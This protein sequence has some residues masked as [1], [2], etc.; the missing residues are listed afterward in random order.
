MTNWSIWINVSFIHMINYQYDTL[1]HMIHWYIWFTEPYGTLIHM[2]NWAIWYIE[3][4][5]SL[6]HMIHWAIWYIDPYD[7]LSHMV[8]WSMWFINPYDTLSHVIL[9]AFSNHF[10]RHGCTTPHYQPMGLSVDHFL[11]FMSWWTYVIETVSALQTFC[12]HWPLV[13]SLCKGPA[14]WIFDVFFVLFWIIC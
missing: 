12:E 3:P 2:I 14:M 6:I 10:F 4:Y 5:D 13:D 7:K 8:H 1:I 11:Q 9:W